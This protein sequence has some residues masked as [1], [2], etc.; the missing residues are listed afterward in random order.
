MTDDVLKQ[1][2]AESE[3]HDHP[4]EGWDD[5]HQDNCGPGMPCKCNKANPPW[6]FGRELDA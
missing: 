3:E 4:E 1:W 5:W 6:H 2:E